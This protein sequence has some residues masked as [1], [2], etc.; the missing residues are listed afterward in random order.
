[1][2]SETENPQEVKIV[3]PIS[4]RG[5]LK[6]IRVDTLRSVHIVV[7]SRDGSC[8]FFQAIVVKL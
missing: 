5:M 1:M 7:F 3:Y 4:R 2:I 6:L 8:M